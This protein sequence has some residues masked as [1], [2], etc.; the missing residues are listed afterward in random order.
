MS[1]PRH[2]YLSRQECRDA[3]RDGPAAT[4][5]Q[6][7]DPPTELRG[8][9]YFLL[10]LPS[11]FATA[12]SPT[13]PPFPSSS[14]PA[15]F[16]HPHTQEPCRRRRLSAPAPCVIA[17]A[18][19]VGGATGG[20]TKGGVRR[21]WAESRVYCPRARSQI[22]SGSRGWSLQ[23]GKVGALRVHAPPGRTQRRTDRRAGGSG[24]GKGVAASAPWEGW[25]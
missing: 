9:V 18:T 7:S 5:P 16:L 12:P 13:Q 20:G 14:Q 4:T 19:L 17:R 25:P 2:R 6:V 15:A 10:L 23:P 24:S 3:T 1:T 8:S 22:A 21:S 11:L